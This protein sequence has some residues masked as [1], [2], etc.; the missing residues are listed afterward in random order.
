MCKPPS[1]MFLHLHNDLL[2]RLILYG[3]TSDSLNFHARDKSASFLNCC[4]NSE[5]IYLNRNGYYL[6]SNFTANNA[7]EWMRM[8]IFGIIFKCHDKS[9]DILIAR[10]WKILSKYIFIWLCCNNLVPSVI[11]WN[12]CCCPVL[13]GINRSKTEVKICSDNW[14]M[15]LSTNYCQINLCS[16]KWLMS[17]YF[18]N[19]YFMNPLGSSYSQKHSL[20]K[21]ILF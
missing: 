7:L 4:S 20:H 18:L 6:K 2:F 13:S 5:S 8:V 14:Q 1:Q 10:I 9:Y 12:C 15:Y 3:N 17:F 11:L 19:G 21:H 16:H